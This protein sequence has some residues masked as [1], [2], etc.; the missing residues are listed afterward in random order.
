MPASLL[1]SLGDPARVSP[2]LRDRARRLC[3]RAGAARGQ[4]RPA[5][6]ARSWSKICA[7]VSPISCSAGWVDRVFT[8]YPR[9]RR[10]FS[11]RAGDRDR[12][13]G[14]LAESAGGRPAAIN[15]RCWFSAAA[16][17][18]GGS[19]TRWWTRSKLL[20]DL[21]RRNLHHASNRRIG[22]RG[23]QRSLRCAALRCRSDAVH[24]RHGRG[25]R[26]A[27][28]WCFAAPARPPSRSS[29]PSAKRRFWCRIRTRFTIISAVT[30]QALQ[31]QRR[32][33][34]DFGS[35]SERQDF[36]AS[37]FAVISPIAA[38]L[39][40]M[41]AAARALGRPEAAARIVDECYALGAGIAVWRWRRISCCRRNIRFISS[42]SA[43]SA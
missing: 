9:E 42:A 27:P 43:A 14:A 11:R 38:R 12:Q 21:T 3:L 25:L 39:E 28:I 37:A 19:I 31:E 30:L 5:F 33:G 13:S 6:A 8:A 1:R 40:R 7:R 20:I 16:P 34:D 23:D 17:A 24:R 18:R 26:A 35:G 29:R 41:A 22:F 32:R 10:I 2:G 15:F 36:G 4:A